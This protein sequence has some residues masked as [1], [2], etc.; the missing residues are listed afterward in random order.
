ML[1]V[2]IFLY[3]IGTQIKFGLDSSA[4]E[5]PLGFT[6][7]GIY[8]SCFFAFATVYIGGQTPALLFLFLGWGEGIRKRGVQSLGPDDAKPVVA[9]P[10]FR[11]VIY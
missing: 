3:A 2:I 8:L 1:F 7:A 9:P 4:K 10:P 11:K 6:F 5:P